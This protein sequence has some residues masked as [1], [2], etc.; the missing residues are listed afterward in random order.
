M[1]ELSARQILVHASMR[2]HLVA[3]QQPF[4]NQFR[5][6]NIQF[7]FRPGCHPR[8]AH[9]W[10]SRDLAETSPQKVRKIL[11]YLARDSDIENWITQAQALVRE[12]AL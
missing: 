4:R 1:L 8:W 5:P 6:K 10:L 9:S 7:S 12:Q 3:G 2:A 11:G